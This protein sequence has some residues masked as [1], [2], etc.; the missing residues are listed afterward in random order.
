M[1]RYLTKEWW[2]DFLITVPTNEGSKEIHDGQKFES[3]VAILLKEMYRNQNIN[4]TKTPMTHDG[5]HDFWAKDQDGNFLWAECKNYEKSISL[6]TIA[7]TIVM[8]EIKDISK[9]L[10]FSY[11]PI[12]KNTKENLMLY[13]KNANREVCFFDDVNLENLIFQYR[14]SVFKTFFKGFKITAQMN[15]DYSPYI[16]TRYGKGIHISTD[17]K[18]NPRRISAKLNDII[19]ICIGI[20]NNHPNCELNF[21]ISLSKPNDIEHFTYLDTPDKTDSIINLNISDSILPGASRLYPFFFKLKIFKSEIKLPE[22]AVTCKSPFFNETKTINAPVIECSNLYVTELMGSQ[23]KNQLTNFREYLNQGHFCVNILEGVSGVGKTRMLNEYMNILLSYHYQIISF[24][25]INGDT[26]SAQIIKEI[27]YNI[28]NLSEDFIIESFKE[29]Q[30]YP[31]EF[32]SDI[33][34]VLQ[35][36]QELTNSDDSLSLLKNKKFAFIYEKL[37]NSKVGILIDNIQYFDEVLINFLGDLCYY[38]KNANRECNTILVLTHNTDYETSQILLKFYSQL[39]ILKDSINI[40]VKKSLLEGFKVTESEPTQALNYLKALI[41]VEDDELDSE[42]NKIVKIS[43]GNP[44]YMLEIVEYLQQRCILEFHN[45]FLVITDHKAFSKQLELLPDNIQDTIQERWNLI[46]NE[47]NQ[48]L[49]NAYLILSAIHFWRNCSGELLEK[50]LM[51]T[52]LLDFLEKRGIIQQKTSKESTN[53][54]FEHDLIECFFSKQEKFSSLIIDYIREHDLLDIL[55][56]DLETWQIYYIKLDISDLD[57]NLLYTT[58]THICE[59]SIEI[60][61]KWGLN[62]YNHLIQYLIKYF[63]KCQNE[64]LLLGASRTICLKIKNVYGAMAA[65]TQYKQLYNFF[66][67]CLSQQRYLNKEYLN[68]VNGYTENLLH[69]DREEVVNIYKKQ[70]AALKPYSN[71]YPDILGMLYNRIYVY[72][73]D[74]RPEEEMHHYFFYCQ[75]ICEKYHLHELEMLNYFDAGNYYLYEE[76]KINLLINNWEKALKIY[77]NKH[78]ED[79]FL[80]ISKKKIQL[81]F[82]KK[83][84]ESTYKKIELA[85]HYLIDNENGYE[86]SLFFS[87]SLAVLEAIFYLLTDSENEN[88]QYCLSQALEYNVQMESTKLFNIYFLYAKMFYFRQQY[89]KMIFYYERSLQNLNNCSGMYCKNFLNQVIFEDFEYKLSCLELK[90]ISIDCDSF[91]QKKT[92][93]LW[94]QIKSKSKLELEQ[95]VENFKTRSNISSIDEKDGY[96]FL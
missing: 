21:S 80:F 23:Y 11:S 52:D 47:L 95:Y 46:K 2:K 65:E 91:Q 83:T 37:V 40:T 79:A 49:H 33:T 92:L 30:Q 53:Y 66:E 59:G 45:N 89:A 88:L 29:S 34:L 68:F 51:D 85:R 74:K 71:Q 3:L 42:L 22:I 62:F 70:I 84:Y 58:M 77:D 16:F 93:K 86:Q 44:K 24:I 38:C 20:V 87:K 73:K 64:E 1:F 19:Y 55:K 72:Y 50:L 90:K 56:P 75:K 61:F 28:Y 18:Q 31:E 36:L 15:L 76:K 60:P 35:I 17:N 4:W 6:K 96:I 10:F 43:S 9:I 81:D 94:R 82:I 41:A 69:M 78:F 27:I 14:K 7:S 5:A 13:A 48:K 57:E 39:Q 8:V 67:S 12:N 26:S 32:G 54:I 25:G 63:E